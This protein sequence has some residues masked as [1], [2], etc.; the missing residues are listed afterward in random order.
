MPIKTAYIKQLKEMTFVGKTDSN[1]WITMDGSVESGES[2]AGIRP[3]ELL[4]LGFGV[5]LVMT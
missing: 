5:V 3:K 1:H 4:L 2:D